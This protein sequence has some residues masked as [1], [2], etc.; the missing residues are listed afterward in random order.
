MSSEIKRMNY[1]DGLFLGS[2]D[3]Q[4]EQDYNMRMRRLH[5]RHHHGGGIVWGLEVEITADTLEIV[6]KPGMALDRYFDEKHGEMS[7][8]E[9]IVDKDQTLSLAGQGYPAGTEIYLWM[10]YREMEADRVEERGGIHPIHIQETATFSHSTEK[11]QDEDSNILLAR[12]VIG[13]DGKFGTDSV[14]YEDDDGTS[15]RRYSGIRMKRFETDL[16]VF[17]NP[18]ISESYPELESKLYDDGKRG[19]V[20]S[21]DRTQIVGDLEVEGNRAKISGNMDIVGN[22]KL[23]GSMKIESPDVEPSTLQMSTGVPVSEF[24]D[25]GTLSDNSDTALPTEHAVKSYVDRELTQG[26]NQESAERQALEAALSGVILGGIAPNEND[27]PVI[28]SGV[29]GI[30]S[31]LITLSEDIPC[32]DWSDSQGVDAPI[33]CQWYVRLLNENGQSLTEAIAGPKKGNTV[34]VN[35][36]NYSSASGDG[37]FHTDSNLESASFG[38]QPGNL[39]F[40]TGYSTIGIKDGY[41]KIASILGSTFKITTNYSQSLEAPGTASAF[42]PVDGTQT[43][44]GPNLHYGVGHTLQST[45]EGYYS[46][47]NSGYRAIGLFYVNESGTIPLDYFHNFGTR[48]SNEQ[49]ITKLVNQYYTKPEMDSFFE[50]TSS[51]KKQIHWDRVT[52]KESVPEMDQENI[53]SGK[54]TFRSVNQLGLHLINSDSIELSYYKSGD[55]TSFIDFHADD[56]YDDYSARLIRR[57]GQNGELELNNR[58]TGAT[59]LYD[60]TGNGQILSSANSPGVYNLKYKNINVIVGDGEHYGSI[61]W[62]T[63]NMPS[64]MES[65]D[66]VRMV[67][68]ENA[69]ADR[70]YGIDATNINGFIPG[71]YNYS[72]TVFTV[73]RKGTSER[74]T[75]RVRLF[76]E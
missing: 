28:M 47:R 13:D 25:D 45:P 37:Q 11:P 26:L 42:M 19:V 76:W 50:G 44:E 7:S 32:N 55:R 71:S 6:V 59:K 2:E 65:G 31:K 1:F 14:Y 9:I 63:I 33:K 20:L 67:T 10:S 35:S 5:N 74:E 58:G 43:G 49:L 39:I 68:L 66:R 62:A 15:V 46:L 69:Q 40:I 38:W 16:I 34:I 56:Y 4:W 8:R 22:M 36:Y 41:Y 3:F 21:S 64:N 61:T 57:M 27:P 29:Y 48:K 12:L 17:T 72:D 51:G 23:S 75:I 70:W 52:G 30:Q 73:Y 60:H 54:Q 18:E 53:W 24:S